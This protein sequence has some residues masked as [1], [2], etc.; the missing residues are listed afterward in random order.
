MA[1][2]QQGWEENLEYRDKKPA[3]V[4]R[5]YQKVQTL[6][7]NKGRSTR[8]KCRY[9]TFTGTATSSAPSRMSITITVC[10]IT[11]SKDLV[12]SSPGTFANLSL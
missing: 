4:R 5:S 8:A 7:G 2:I 3:G 1:T 10:L 12:D 6:L 9:S 11:L